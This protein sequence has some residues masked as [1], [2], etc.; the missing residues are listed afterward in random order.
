MGKANLNELWFGRGTGEGTFPSA[1][2]LNV[3]ERHGRAHSPAPQFLVRLNRFRA[4]S[5]AALSL[6]WRKD[7]A[8]LLH[9][10]QHI[11]HFPTFNNLAFGQAKDADGRH[12]HPKDKEKQ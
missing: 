5:A 8:E 3:R 2:S 4:G 12:R 9:Q 11:Q 6:A 7:R 1:H 10:A